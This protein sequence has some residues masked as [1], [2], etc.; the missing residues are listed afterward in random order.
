MNTLNVIQQWNGKETEIILRMIS[1]CLFIRIH[2]EIYYQK[3]VKKED[4]DFVQNCKKKVAEIHLKTIQTISKLRI[5]FQTSSKAK[6]DQ[7]LLSY[8]AQNWKAP[9]E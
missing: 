6:T 5:N 1:E 2:V 4:E 9:K 3:L 8:I 7:I